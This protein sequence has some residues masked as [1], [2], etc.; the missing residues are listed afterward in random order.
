VS[1]IDP[2]TVRLGGATPFSGF[3]RRINADQWPDVT[4][5]FQ[6][7]E[8]ELPPGYANATLTGELS[9]GTTFSSTVRVFNRDDSFYGA[10]ENQS[11]ELRQVVW[12]TRR[13]GSTIVPASDL[14]PLGAP[15]ITA[16]PSGPRVSMRSST[17]DLDRVEPEGR[18]VV[19]I[20]RR[21]PVVARDEATT[22]R[23]SRTTRRL[24]ETLDQM[25]DAELHAM[26]R[27]SQ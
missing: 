15:A 21:E 26:A 14:E 25:T 16:V 1:K 9:D 4:F 8:V 12:D 7:N 6:G 17:R 20:P 3:Q 22:P 2:A 24:D 11:A 5:V 23:A 10:P 13:D 19:S 18:P 27:G